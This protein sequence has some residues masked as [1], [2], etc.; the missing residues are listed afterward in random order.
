MGNRCSS[1]SDDDEGRQA[2]G[3]SVDPQ[4]PKKPCQD[5]VRPTASELTITEEQ[6]IRS[7]AEVGD[8]VAGLSA[9]EI[10]NGELADPDWGLDYR[11]PPS[12]LFTSTCEA[13]ASGALR[14][15]RSC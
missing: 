5:I 11:P 8:C 10:E 2:V 14:E 6:L 9:A 7:A 1:P 13:I 4:R 12:S 3:S 15:C